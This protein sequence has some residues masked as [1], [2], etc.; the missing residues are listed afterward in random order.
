MRRFSLCISLC[1]LFPPPPTNQPH[2]G[3]TNNHG[4]NNNTAT[5]PPPLP[6]TADATTTS[7]TTVSPQRWLLPSLATRAV[8][9]LSG[10][11]VIL[12]SPSIPRPPIPCWLHHSSP[13]LFEYAINN[14]TISH[15]TSLWIFRDGNEACIIHIRRISDCLTA[16]RW[17]KVY[18]IQQSTTYITEEN[19]GAASKEIWKCINVTIINNKF[20]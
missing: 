4:G 17:G 10:N 20:K 9:F 19:F 13:I 18:N 11:H 3:R 14:T 12:T 1:I 15:A 7:L 16:C 8:C 6:L 5:T 2:T